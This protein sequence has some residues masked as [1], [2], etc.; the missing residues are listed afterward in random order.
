MSYRCAAYAILGCKSRL[1]SLNMLSTHSSGLESTACLVDLRLR[2]PMDAHFQQLNGSALIPGITIIDAYLFVSM[3][4]V[5]PCSP[6]TQRFIGPRLSQD[7]DD[8]EQSF[9]DIF[10][11]DLAPPVVH[12]VQNSNN[13]RNFNEFLAATKWG[14]ENIDNSISSLD[15]CQS[16]C[17][18]F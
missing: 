18:V 14:S 2:D 15:Y 8:D 3:K 17:G 10:R 1:L 6:H 16:Y 11:A 7:D 5:H 4:I 9:I 13:F 12:S